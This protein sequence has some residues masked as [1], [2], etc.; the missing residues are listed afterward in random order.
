MF[1]LYSHKAPFYNKTFQTV[2]HKTNVKKEGIENGYQGFGV[3]CFLFT[4]CTKKEDS[5]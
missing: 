2:R 3:S 1:D 4:C 5:G